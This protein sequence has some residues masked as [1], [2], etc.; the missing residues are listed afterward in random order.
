MFFSNARPRL[1]IDCEKLE[2]N[3]YL[4]KEKVENNA[5]DYRLPIDIFPTLFKT[6]QDLLK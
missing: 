6:Q 5:I 3:R 2:T 4:I 1:E